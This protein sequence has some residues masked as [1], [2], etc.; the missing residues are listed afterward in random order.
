MKEAYMYIHNPVLKIDVKER[1]FIHYQITCILFFCWEN[2]LRWDKA[3]VYIFNK[4]C[5]RANY[6]S[7]AEDGIST[8]RTTVRMAAL[9]IRRDKMWMKES[10]E[11]FNDFLSNVWLEKTRENGIAKSCRIKVVLFF[12]LMSL[13]WKNSIGNFR[14]QVLRFIEFLL[15]TSVLHLLPYSSSWLMTT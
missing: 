2:S 12:Q 9:Q 14:D 4:A 8:L 11:V 5:Q 6:V 7:N 10:C 1:C 13:P 15:K 3:A